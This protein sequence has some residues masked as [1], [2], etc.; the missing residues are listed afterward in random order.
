[1]GK[2][3]G[4]VETHIGALFSVR[5]APMVWFHT[6]ADLELQPEGRTP[7]GTVHEE[8]HI[9]GRINARAGEEHEEEDR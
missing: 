1:M 4:P 5:N 8:L 3:Y 9:M 7:F 2:N 6:G